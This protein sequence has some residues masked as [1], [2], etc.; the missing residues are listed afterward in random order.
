MLLA[1]EPQDFADAVERV[2]ADR[3]LAARLGADA[4]RARGGSVQLEVGGRGLERFYGDLLRR[5]P[6]TRRRPTLAEMRRRTGVERFCGNTSCHT[7]PVIGVTHLLKRRRNVGATRGIVVSMVLAGVLL[8]DGLRWRRQPSARVRQHPPDDHRRPTPTRDDRLRRAPPSTEPVQLGPWVDA[9]ANLAGMP[10]EC[11]NMSYVGANPGRDQLIAGVAEQGLW[12]N[13]AG[14][15]PVDADSAA[16]SQTGRRRSSSTR[17]FPIDSGRAGTTAAPGAFRTVDGGQTFQRA[18]ARRISTGS[19][20]TCPTRIARR[21]SR[22]RTNGLSC[23]ARPTAEQPGRTSLPAS[24]RA[25]GSPPSRSCST[26]SATSSG[27]LDGDASGIFLTT[28]GGATWT[29]VATN[30]VVGPPLV[31]QDGAIYWV[32]EGARGLIRSD[33]HRRDVD[34]R[35]RRW[36]AGLAQPRRAARWEAGGGRPHTR[37]CLG[38]SGRDLAGVR[39]G[40]PDERALTG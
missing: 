4:R 19:A 27:R 2:L 22:G 18:R 39:A 3:P 5:V 30:S 38:R 11:G 36:S 14:D 13:D 20:W 32:L 17:T 1:D 31:A 16:A 29:Q 21:C 37:R 15:R 24:R 9:T 28:D 34:G 6:D 8:G 25:S 7:H 12:Q 33:R 26:R 10:S 35:D 40:R 23:S